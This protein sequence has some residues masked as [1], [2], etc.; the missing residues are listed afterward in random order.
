MDRRNRI[1]IE[2]GK[3]SLFEYE[4]SKKVIHLLR[5]AQKVGSFL[6]NKRKS[7]ESIPTVY[8][9]VRRSM[10]SRLGS[11]RKSKK[12]I[13]VLHWWFRNNYLFPSSSRTFRTQSYWS[14]IAGQCCD[15]ERI[16]P[17]YLP[18]WM[19]FLIF[20]LSSTM[21]WYLEVKIQAR[22]RQY[23]F[24][25]LIQET[26]IIK[27][28]N[29]LTS[30]YHVERDTCTVHRRNIKTRYFGF[31]TSR[32]EQ[33]IG[34]RTCSTTRRTSCATIQKFPIEP[35][36]S[37]PKSWQIGATRCRSSNENRA[38]WKKKGPFPGDRCKFFSR[39]DCLFRE[40]GATRCRN[41]WNPITFIWW[42]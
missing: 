23:S 38:R 1:D 18:Y 39:R 14:F 26:K 31:L 25:P 15:S 19:C 5:H 35:T 32:L 21:D 3:Y 24:C 12:E 9:L 16:L 42:Q 22:D 11:K 13:P 36:N 17:T 29:I 34:F 10:E 27:I 20:I 28:L 37:K 8:S 2:P 7:L 33:R 6:E 40:I 30:L 4:V 41:E